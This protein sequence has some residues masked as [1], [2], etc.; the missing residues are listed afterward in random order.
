M[1]EITPLLRTSGH[2]CQGKGLRTAHSGSHCA[3]FIAVAPLM[4][5]TL[6]DEVQCLRACGHSGRRDSA[7]DSLAVMC[8]VGADGAGKDAVQRM[9]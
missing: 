5:R 8:V 3:H 2:T 7:N 1:A 4:K 9:L 6:G